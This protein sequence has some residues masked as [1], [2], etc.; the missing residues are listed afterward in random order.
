M[1]KAAQSNPEDSGKLEIF[2]KSLSFDVDDAALSK[3]F[4]KYGNMTKCKLI[5]A[6]GRSKG[7]A[8]VEYDNSSSA[9]A[10][11]DGENG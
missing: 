2:V 3:I 9:Q 7:I 8:F 10:A 4:G 5:T 11:V 1:K 6:N